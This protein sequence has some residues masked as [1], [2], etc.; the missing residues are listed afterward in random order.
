M[1]WLTDHGWGLYYLFTVLAYLLGGYYLLAVNPQAMVTMASDA[2]D[3][4]GSFAGMVEDA[5]QMVE[6]I[7]AALG[8]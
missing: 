7:V 4:A 1:N 2:S 3:L 5:K 6:S 8:G